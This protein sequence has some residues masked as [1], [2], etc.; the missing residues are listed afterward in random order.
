MSN[1]AMHNFRT[2]CRML[3]CWLC[4]RSNVKKLRA[5][6]IY[7]GHYCR[8]PECMVESERSWVVKGTGER[9]L[10]KLDRHVPV[11]VVEWS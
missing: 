10:P 6:G 11:S 9:N 8:S 5:T 4:W 2:V 1:M 7:P 3:C